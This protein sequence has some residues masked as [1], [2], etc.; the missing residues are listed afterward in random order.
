MC[1]PYDLQVLL[2]ELEVEA[3]VEV[4][5]HC[6]VEQEGHQRAVVLVEHPRPVR[7]DREALQDEV[8]R[9]NRTQ[10]PHR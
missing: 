4:Q 9:G 8:P 2:D 3:Q 1:L 5:Q 7:Q 6:G 10:E